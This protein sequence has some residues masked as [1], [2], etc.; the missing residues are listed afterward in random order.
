MQF[1]SIDAMQTAT[2]LKEMVA[3]MWGVIPLSGPDKPFVKYYL[4]YWQSQMFATLGFG[5][6]P[7]F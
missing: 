2:K 4:N 5:I 6:L 1:Q 7:T 3:G